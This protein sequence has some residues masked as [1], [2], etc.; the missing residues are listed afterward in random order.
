MCRTWQQY[1]IAVQYVLLPWYGANLEGSDGDHVFLERVEIPVQ[2]LGKARSG[3]R[4]FTA[5]AVCMFLLTTLDMHC[6]GCLV[7]CSNRTWVVASKWWG[8]H[9]RLGPSVSISSRG[10]PLPL[11]RSISSAVTKM[12]PTAQVPFQNSLMVPS[13]ASSAQ[14]EGPESIRCTLLHHHEAQHW[15]YLGGLSAGLYFMVHS[16]GLRH[17]AGL[18]CHSRQRLRRVPHLPSP[19]SAC[20]SCRW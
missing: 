14:S 20:W 10:F 5:C 13:L 8:A 16:S 4:A 6:Q 18:S 11:A 3:A 17:C 12:S 2:L 15:S 9:R 19:T 1:P 7:P